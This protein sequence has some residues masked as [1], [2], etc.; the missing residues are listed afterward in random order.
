MPFTISTNAV[1]DCLWNPRFARLPCF[2]VV[3]LVGLFAATTNADIE[4]RDWCVASTI[5]FDLVSDLPR[6]EAL[7]LLGALDQFRLATAPLLPGH[8]DV[9]ATPLKLLVFARARDFDTTFNSTTMA[10]FARPSLDQSLLVSRPDRDRGH[11]L[12][13]VY[14]E[15]THYLIRSRAFL[16]LPIWYEEGLASYL[17]TLVV[18][19]DGTTVV[20]RVPYDYIRRALLDP[21][22]SVIHILGQRFRL[23]VGSHQVSNTYGV[24]WALVRFL[25]HAKAPDGSRYASRLGAMLEMIDGGADSVDAMEATMG[26]SPASLKRRLQKYFETDQL[27][28]FRF[29][30]DTADRIAFRYHCLEPAEARHELAMAAAFHHPQ[31]AV[32]LFSETIESAPDHTGALV[33]LSRLMDGERA[34]ELAERAHRIDPDDGR[35]K[36]RLAEMRLRGCQTDLTTGRSR[37]DG[38]RK[39][40]AMPRD[41]RPRPA[42]GHAVTASCAQKI[43]DAIALYREALEMPGHAGA[44]AYGL[45]V[46][47]LMVGRS[48]DALT[49]L[50]AAYARASWSPQISFFLGEAYRRS[51]NLLRA[52][53]YFTKSAHWHPE[54]SWRDRSDL[55]LASITQGQ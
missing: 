51:G 25:H 37:G 14:H 26:L 50:R 32:S 16:N 31:F 21:G 8:S 36:I 15:Y 20:G 43:S 46:V 49:Y 22:I 34:V 12:R 29:R 44:A 3:V 42:N 18:E 11:L 9:P 2:A 53:Q 45:G 48:D 5:H 41:G 10:G 13:N 27:P 6:E 23:G 52:R 33:G 30:A 17:S 4:D 24:A 39:G 7:A 38:T 40:D 19:P 1:S 47:S 54:Q 35:A 28:V 55:V